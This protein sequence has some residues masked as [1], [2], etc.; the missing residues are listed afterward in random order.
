MSPRVGYPINFFKKNPG[1][2]GS[3]DFG[4]LPESPNT[5]THHKN[6]G[7]FEVR[8]GGWFPLGS[9]WWVPLIPRH[10][11]ELI[12]IFK[13]TT[14]TFTIVSYQIHNRTRGANRRTMIGLDTHAIPLLL[15]ESQKTHTHTHTHTQIYG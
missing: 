2:L 9:R 5:N 6:Y 11:P 14:K 8:Q 15:K 4:G 1:G 7:W 10:P 3:R 12:K 13:L